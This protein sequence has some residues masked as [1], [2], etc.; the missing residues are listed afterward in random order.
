MRLISVFIL[1][2]VFV[3]EAFSQI[4]S[5][6]VDEVVVSANR[7]PSVYSQTSRVVSIITKEELRNL[8]VQTIQDVLK[9]ALN[10][11]IRQRG[12]QG[13]QADVCIRGGSFDQTLILLNGVNINDPQTGHH[14]LDLPVDINNIKKIEILQGP[15][16]RV[17][18]PNAFAGAINI[19]TN[20]NNDNDNINLSIMGGEHNYFSGSLSSSYKIDNINNYVSISRR[21]S[22]GYTDDTDFDIS[23]L[24]YHASTKLN[25]AKFD[26]QA[27]YT[28]K[29]FGANSFYTPKFPDQFEATKTTFIS[30]KLT[31]FGKFKFIPD[32]YW[33]RHQ[34]KF[35]LFRNNPP[36]WYS[37]H[38]YHLTDVYGININSYFDWKYGRTSF[39]TNYRAENILSNV[40]GDLM[41]DTIAVPG[42]PNA[43]FTHSKLRN[44][45]SFFVEHIVHLN[46]FSFSTGFLAN[47][48]S[49]FSWNYTPG[50]DLSYN[51]TNNFKIFSTINKSVRMPT[52]TDLY[53]VGPTN[54]GNK[55]LKPE[56]AVSY[57][58]GAK[59]I[60]KWININSS[61]FI[62]N[63]RNVIDWVKRVDSLLWESKNITEL[64]TKGF[65]FSGIFYTKQLYNNTFPIDYI[66]VNYS[67]ISSNK[68]S[69]NYISYYAL[70]YLK[71]KLVIS[72]QNK[73]YKKIGASYSF[74]YQDRAGT[75][76]D[77]KTGLEKEYKPF[78]TIDARLFYKCKSFN[79]Y[80]EAS[81]I[82]NK[83]YFDIGNVEMPGRWI[84]LG[85]K[86]N[87]KLKKIVKCLFSAHYTLLNKVI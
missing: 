71:H 58:V 3:S 11:D 56:K 33:R 80:A 36:S 67:Y 20:N 4:D 7:A 8:P 17:F 57:E 84:R 13:V 27:G 68:N 38:N 15:G 62:R 43:F 18:G 85:V 63:S 47:Y 65:D 39:G 73:I 78:S 59:F 64:N 34:D 26:V 23:N 87:F 40:L 14:N 50:I 25:F 28:N 46:K 76:T 21:K 61:I 86:F 69:E 41:N 35:E 19:I 12:S 30:A 74:V 9:Y 1:L 29:K 49:D 77:F 60:N 16:S 42:E 53:Y 52:F 2:M 83:K 10:V 48:N 55:N 6:N 5:V 45:L 22:D 54:V 44:N 66:K 75:Y 51:L 72:L 82:F 24:F 37:G 81:N 70:D 79:I 32:I 31:G